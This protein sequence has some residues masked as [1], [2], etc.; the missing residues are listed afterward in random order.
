MSSLR[1]GLFH[2]LARQKPFNHFKKSLFC[3]SWL[4]REISEGYLVGENYCDGVLCP[5]P[6]SI[7][8]FQAY[9]EA[10]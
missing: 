1:E 6:K 10:R 8:E 4:P 5:N 7:G 3:P 9:T 2:C